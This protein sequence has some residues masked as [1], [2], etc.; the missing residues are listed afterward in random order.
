MKVQ[1]KQ[2]WWNLRWTRKRDPQ[3][4]IANKTET[5]NMTT[6]RLNHLNTTTL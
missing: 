1:E 3:I 5:R 2:T 6:G 4:G